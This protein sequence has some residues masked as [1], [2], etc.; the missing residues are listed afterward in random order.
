M[1][2]ATHYRSNRNISFGERGIERDVD[3]FCDK[4]EM[5]VGQNCTLDVKSIKFNIHF[6]HFMHIELVR[7]SFDVDLMK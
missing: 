5:L 2:T 7:Y 6:V 4:H 1:E 3:N